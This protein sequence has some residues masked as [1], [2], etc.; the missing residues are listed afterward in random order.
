MARPYIELRGISRFRYQGDYVAVAQTQLATGKFAPRWILQGFV[1]I[2]SASDEAGSL[3]QQ[4]EAWGTGF[5]YLVAPSV[6]F[7]Y[8]RRCRI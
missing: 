2:G 8:R 3:W 7:I 5:R 4:T 1:G 6:W